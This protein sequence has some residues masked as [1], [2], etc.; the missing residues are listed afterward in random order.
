MNSMQKI[1]T[2]AVVAI[3]LDARGRAVFVEDVN[4]VERDGR[5]LACN[6]GRPALADSHV[7]SFRKAVNLTR[8]CWVNGRCYP[9]SLV[10]YLL[11]LV[12]QLFRNLFR[13]A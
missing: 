2:E 3:Y 7:V 6:D 12:Y 4:K 5:A 9:C 13:T 11:L 1:P 10:E 8:C